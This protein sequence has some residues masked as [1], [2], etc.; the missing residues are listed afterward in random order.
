VKLQIKQ[1][2]CK[3]CEK[4]VYPEEGFQLDSSWWHGA[5]FKCDVCKGRI[6]PGNYA[7]LKGNYYCK[8]HFKQLFALKGNYDE[9]FGRAQHKEKWLPGG[10]KE[11]ADGAESSEPASPRPPAI[12]ASSPPG[13]PVSPKEEPLSPSVVKYVQSEAK[14]KHM[15]IKLSG[16]TLED[17]E[18]A[19]QEFK[20]I[21]S[22]G[23][24]AISED[25]FLVLIEEVMTKKGK[26]MGKIVLKTT[27]KTYFQAYD[28]DKNGVIDEAE[29]L[30]IYSDLLL[31][32]EKNP[33]SPASPAAS[34]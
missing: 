9:G 31:E 27:S 30:Q 18:A 32:K 10:K 12:E 8:T 4:T 24:G 5:C 3:L 21:N 15:P 26:V 1:N 2:K 23:S 25:E 33:S 13:S 20:R 16:L 7:S 28:K 34:P 6:T 19:Q 29:F 17:V 22:S 11:R 14:V